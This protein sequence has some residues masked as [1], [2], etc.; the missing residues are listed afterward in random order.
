[1]PWH[2]IYPVHEYLLPHVKT[3]SNTRDTLVL[4]L[5]GTC[6]IRVWP[7]RPQQN[8]D[9]SRQRIEVTLEVDP[10]SIKEFDSKD[11]HPFT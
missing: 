3:M 6:A 5:V 4:V 10:Y 9:W 7:L 1:M 11:N 8:L 2:D